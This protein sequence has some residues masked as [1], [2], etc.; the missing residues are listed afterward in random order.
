MDKRYEKIIE[1]PHHTS[2]TRKPMPLCNRAAQ[3][4]P[5]AALTGFEDIISET[6]ESVII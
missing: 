6:A 4:S 3:F 2:A 1:M 5:F